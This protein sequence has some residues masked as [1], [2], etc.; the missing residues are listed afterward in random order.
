MQ[1]AQISGARIIIEASPEGYDVE[2]SQ[3]THFFHN[4]TAL[5]LGY[6]TIPP[7][8][9][10]QNRHDDGFVDWEWLKRQPAV[11]ETKYLRHVRTSEPLVAFI[12]GRK[13]FGLIA[14]SNDAAG[15]E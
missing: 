3:G 5:R 8:S 1:W 6:F 2:P 11:Q 14:R 9:S 4:I 10:R 7:G 15:S 13:G 12:D